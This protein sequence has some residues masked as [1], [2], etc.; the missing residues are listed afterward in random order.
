MTISLAIINGPSLNLLGFRE[1]K[2]YGTTTLAELTSSLKKEFDS[3]ALLH[4]F[5]SNHEGE[6]IDYI[7]ECRNFC[8]GLIINPAAYSYT[9]FAINDAIRTIALPCIEVH[10]SNIHARESFRANSV[11]ASSCIGQISGLGLH[12]YFL[13]VQALLNICPEIK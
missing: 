9:S 2:I 1:P 3:R 6:L 13:A 12:S 7:H 8:S 10:I 5:Q 11:I 4:F